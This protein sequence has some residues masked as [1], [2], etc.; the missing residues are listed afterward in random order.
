MPFKKGHIGYIPKQSEEHKRK[1]NI[2][3][4]IA[5]K[6]KHNSPKSEF[7]KEMIVKPINEN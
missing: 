2:S 5:L 1:K 7:K 6:G 3:I 4:S